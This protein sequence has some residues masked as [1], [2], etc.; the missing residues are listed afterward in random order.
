VSYEHDFLISYAHIDDQ[1]LV[2]GEK[3]W[4]TR[5]HRLLEIRVGQLSGRTPR[6]WRDPKLQG[7]DY[8]AD[9]IIDRLPRIAALVSIFSPRYVQSEWC[10]RE[11]K[12]FCRVAGHEG[13]VRVG[14]KARIFKVV[15]TPVGQERLPEEV[16]PMLGYEFFVYDPQSGRPRELSPEFG[17]GADRAFLTKLDDLAYDIAQLLEMLERNGAEATVP[18]KGTVFVAETTFDLREERESIMRDLMR[19]GYEV[20]PDR[21]LPLVAGELD[22]L[23]REQIGRSKVSIHL[24]GKNYGVVPEGGRES[25]IVR[26]QAV[27]SEIGRGGALTNLIWIAPGLEIEDER[28]NAFIE[29]LQSDAEV[30]ASAELLQTP[31]EDLKSLIHQ[32]L[33][34]QPT[35]AKAAPAPSQQELTRIFLI[36]DKSDIEA[37]RPLEDRLFD[38]GYEVLPSAFVEDEAEARQEHEES[39][40]SADAILLYYGSASEL[41]LRRKL[42]ELQKSSGLGRQTP[43]LAK[44]IYVAGPPTQQKERFRTLE[45]MLLL[46]PAGGFEPDA[47]APFLAALAGA[48]AGS[49]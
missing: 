19:N 17:P 43:F 32:K 25:S 36:C 23:V 10:N 22:A 47:L 7:N 5:L 13:G 31:L 42:R 11:L 40:R 35:P 48:K 34:P 16:Q 14:D 2:E 9:T 29:H 45:A 6:I 4:V 8:F 28:Q 46:E 12:E 1:A 21:P 24:I 39:M 41:W 44:A 30:H 20:L 3:G 33:A 27:A 49:R 38:A 18:S 37:V 15:K 26:Q